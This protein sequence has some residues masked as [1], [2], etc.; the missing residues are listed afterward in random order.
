[1]ATH[2]PLGEAMRR[3]EFIAALGGAMALPLAVRAQQ[4]ERVR[5]IGVL[6]P[7]AADDHLAQARNG[8]F[9][10]GLQQLGWSLGRN[11][12]I[13]YRWSSGGAADTRRHAAELA[14]LAPDV[15]LASGSVATAP[16]LQETRNVPIVF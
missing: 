12:Q 1:M 16:L 7:Y 2:E 14:T 4:R 5:R 6:M 13:E 10:Q 15:I 9:L 8:T 11:I 3:R